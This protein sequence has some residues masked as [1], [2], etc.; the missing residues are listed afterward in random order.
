MQAIAKHMSEM[1]RKGDSQL[2][3]VMP[4]EIEFLE[5]IGGA[6]TVNPQTGLKEFNTTQ[7][8]IN[9]ALKESGGEW[10]KE[11][12]DLAKQRDAEKGQTYNSSTKTYT[13]TSSSNNSSSNSSNNDSGS[14]TIRQS[15]AN[16]LTP[17]DGMVYENGVLVNSGG[18]RINNNTSWQDA[19]NLSTPNDGKQYVNGQLV[20]DDNQPVNGNH[21]NVFSTALN[22]IGMVANPAAFITSKIIGN[23]A[24]SVMDSFNS[25]SGGSS[26]STP[27]SVYTHPTDNDDDNRGSSSTSTVSEVGDGATDATDTTASEAAEISGDFGYS[28][29]SN[30]SSRLNGSSLIEYD[31]TDGTGQKVG[32]YN[33][34][35]K[36][37]HIT[38]SAENS[39]AYAMTEQGSNMIEQLISQLPRDIMDKL[40]GNVS[41]FTTADNKVALVAGDQQTGLVEA[42]YDANKDGYTNAMNDVGA[43]LE[44]ARVEN[45]TTIDAGYMGRVASYQKY[46][47]Y[48]TPGLQ[49]EKSRLMIELQ[50]YDQGSP[51]YNS[52]MAS[53]AS[54][55]RELQRR[56]RDGQEVTTAYSIDGVTEQISQSIRDQVA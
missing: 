24:N 1:G 26:S 37:F 10:T 25:D 54:L 13:S 46:K 29:V 9:S 2:I 51:Q 8:K 20:N 28:T 33:G 39:R 45:D 5:K 42:T 11:V 48:E 19:A 36:P 27:R 15:F 14:N 3:H 17:G 30:F 49:I 38:T 12:N 56:T 23:V 53:L 4:E 41:M 6:G 7:D 47:G 52:A 44:Y 32:T 16:L 21:E 55:D 22:V 43:M 31:Y 50:N 35:E 40:Q 18:Q 34:N